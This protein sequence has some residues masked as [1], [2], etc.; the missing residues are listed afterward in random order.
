MVELSG[1]ST[2]QRAAHYLFRPKVLA[3]II[4]GVI[5]GSSA[6]IGTWSLS[7][8]AVEQTIISGEPTTATETPY[9]FWDQ[10]QIA[11]LQEQYRAGKGGATWSSI[12]N[13]AKTKLLDQPPTSI[14]LKAEA[15]PSGD[16][17]D[18]WTWAKYVWLNPI[19]GQ[20]EYRDGETN[21]TQTAI[22]NDNEKFWDFSAAVAG[23]ALA[24]KISTDPVYSNALANIVRTWII[25]PETRMNPNLNY[26]QFVPGY[27][28]ETRTKSGI[29]ELNGAYELWDAM[30]TVLTLPTLT[31]GE[32]ETVRAWLEGFYGWL[33]TDAGSIKE[34][35]T[36]NNH[37]TYWHLNVVTLAR[38]LG[39]TEATRTYLEAVRPIIAAQ[40][41]PSG[42]MP[43]ETRRTLSYGYTVFNLRAFSLLAH[44]GS[45]TGVDLWGYKT[46][47]GRSIVRALAFTEPYLLQKAPWPYLQNSPMSSFDY[48]CAE[49]AYRYAAASLGASYAVTADQIAAKYSVSS[50]RSTFVPVKVIAAT[51]DSNS[52][53][54]ANGGT[55]NNNRPGTKSNPLPTQQGQAPVPD[56]GKNTPSTDA[57]TNDG[58]LLDDVAPSES[59]GN[60]GIGSRLAAWWQRVINFFVGI[61]S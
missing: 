1:G 6:A 14:A 36:K 31:L 8:L 52:N 43:E 10:S 37:A 25:N 42:E 56:S 49:T 27:S 19:T 59:T 23:G 46:A 13:W 3:G 50:W 28:S 24:W 29:I 16:K 22:Y 58:F 4:F 39:K 51:N 38:V 11:Q 2:R 7:Y 40:I 26:S 18:F 54:S 57:L 53:T 34:S 33:T 55:A 60:T 12:R 9:I 48:R 35:K 21:Y 44:I 61:F 20:Y 5:V 15:P 41:L 47:D 32:R 45:K 30:P 17:R